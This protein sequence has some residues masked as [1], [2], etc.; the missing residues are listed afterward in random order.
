MMNK[1]KELSLNIEYHPPMNL[2][3]FSKAS[4]LM[5]KALGYIRVL[6]QMCILSVDIFLLSLCCDD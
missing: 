2:V 3:P 6:E 4:P 5:N 1:A